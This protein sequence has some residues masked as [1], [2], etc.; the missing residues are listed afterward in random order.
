MTNNQ[1]DHFSLGTGYEERIYCSYCH[2]PT[3]GLLKESV[4]PPG[5]YRIADNC[6]ER[7]RDDQDDVLKSKF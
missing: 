1:L 4:L 3:T 6:L 5:N 7:I 2:Q